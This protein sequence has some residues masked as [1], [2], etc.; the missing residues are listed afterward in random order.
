MPK[1]THYHRIVHWFQN[2]K[3]FSWVAFL[4]FVVVGL[5]TVIGSVDTL[6]GVYNKYFGAARTPFVAMK[7][8]EILPIPK[9]SHGYLYDV[10]QDSLETLRVTPDY[11]DHN[12]NSTL[13]LKE[14][15]VPLG[16]AHG[17]HQEVADTGQGR[18]SHWRDDNNNEYL[19]FST[20]DNSDPRSNGRQYTATAPDGRSIT[21]DARNVTKANV[22]NHGYRYRGDGLSLSAA[23]SDCDGQ[24]K[25]SRLLVLETEAGREGR[26]WPAHS[27]RRE[28][29]DIGQGRYNHCKDGTT[30]WLFFSTSDNSDPRDN[31]REYALT[32][33]A[34]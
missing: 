26:L 6:V 18:Y 33:I 12:E 11:L 13:V 4:V 8:T 23:N 14:N 17:S 3:V 32:L 24:S 21:L 15:G 5:G 7:T 29:E 34:D 19:Y 31:G 2:N 30:V 22:K 16:P 10:E 20:S 28:I 27:P 9:V 25:I 1:E